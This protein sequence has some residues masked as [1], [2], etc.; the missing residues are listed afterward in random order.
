LLAAVEAAAISGDREAGV[1]AAVSDDRE[2]PFVV[3][4]F[5]PHHLHVLDASGRILLCPIVS[6]SLQTRRL[7]SSAIAPL[8]GRAGIVFRIAEATVSVE[9]G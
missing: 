8:F 9:Q 6:F 4:A 3:L 7:S 1:G 5:R 2:R